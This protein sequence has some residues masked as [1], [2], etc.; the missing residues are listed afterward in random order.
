MEGK[1]RNCF[2]AHFV[3]V[4]VDTELGSV[5]FLKYVAVHESGRIMNPLTATSQIKGGVGMG[6]G[7]ALHENLIYDQRTGIPLVTGYYFD[8]VPT[9]LDVPDVDVTFI[10]ADDGYGPYGAKS[11]GE[12]G[13]IQTP[14]AISNAIYNAIGTRIKDLPITRDKI[15]GALA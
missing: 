13:M 3:E 6:I 9:H 4:E 14:A 11:V 5:R 7:M 12:S 15:L 1:T 8:R 2:G 10:E